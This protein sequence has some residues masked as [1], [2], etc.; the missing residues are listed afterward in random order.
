MSKQVWL[1][2]EGTKKGDMQLAIVEMFV[3]ESEP[4]LALK[5]WVNANGFHLQRL[6]DPIQVS[7]GLDFTGLVMKEARAWAKGVRG[8][9]IR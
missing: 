6:V 1:L 7:N 4:S 3:S 2:R 8:E 5:E 9:D